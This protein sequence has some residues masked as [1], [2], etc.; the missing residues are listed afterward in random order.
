MN[1]K[2]SLRDKAVSVSL[3]KVKSENVAPE[4][5]AQDMQQAFGVHIDAA[6]SIWE[7]LT[8]DAA[9]ETFGPG[10]VADFCPETGLWEEFQ[11]Q[12]TIQCTLQ[13]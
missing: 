13:P 9:S 2:F 3:S 8:F 12:P 10:Y 4:C 1:Y 11:Q 7:V 6:R 5:F